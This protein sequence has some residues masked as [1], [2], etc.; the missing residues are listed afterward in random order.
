MKLLFDQNVSFRIVKKIETFFPNSNQVGQL[1]IENNSDK[2]IWKYTKDN[3]FS[4]VTFD[5]DFFEISNLKGHPPKIIWLR[6][7]NLTTNNIIEILISKKEILIDFLQ[8][9][10]YEEISCL[11]IK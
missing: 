5:A 6:T 8:N 11:E 7:G 3:D 1:G 9:P 4:V 10:L 2:Q